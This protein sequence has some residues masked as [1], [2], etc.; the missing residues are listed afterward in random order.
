M[1]L[2]TN[3]YVYIYIIYIY[4]YYIYEDLNWPILTRQRTADTACDPPCS[5]CPA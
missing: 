3:M 5:I 4:I 1:I 2:H